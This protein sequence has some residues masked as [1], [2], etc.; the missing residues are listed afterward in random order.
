MLAGPREERFESLDI[1]RGVA[2]LGIFAVNII[3]F[4]QPHSVFGNPSIMPE[5][6]NETGGWWRVSQTF[7]QF[8][9]ITI[10]SALFGAGV[11][12]MVGEEK[13]SPRFGIHMRRMMWLF[14]FG[15]IHNYAIWYGDI[16]VPYAVAGLIIVLLRRRSPLVLTI[17]AAVLILIN[18]GLF[19]A[20]GL[21][22]DT[23]T[24]EQIAEMK[25]KMWAPPSEVVQEQI[26]AYQ[27]AWP[28][29]I[30]DTWGV[31]LQFQLIQALGLFPR[32]LGVMMLGMA[33]YKSGFFTLRWS[34][35]VYALLA[36]IGI[37]VGVYFSHVATGA[38]LESNFDFAKATSSQ[39]LLYWA[40]LP[41]ALGYASLVMLIAKLAPNAFFTAPFAAAGRMA[42]TNYLLCS[43]I[44]AF[45]FFGAPG[46]GLIGEWGFDKMALMTVVVWIAILVWSPIWLAVFR[47]GPFEWVWR[48]LTYGRLQPLRK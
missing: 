6:F 38:L 14:L 17:F 24:P 26:A 4:A 28:G 37:G 2:V 43:L 15:M 18:Y 41:Q 48:S 21:M 12:L 10:F 5:M 22:L 40:S 47:F 25:T 20:Q 7:F 46:L 35:I 44:G 23:M 8:K 39:G 1:L 9:F 33:L 13:P 32:T 16:L 34:T 29:R 11:L 19:A 45:V 30:A 42:L 36:F 31:S 27:G 3:A